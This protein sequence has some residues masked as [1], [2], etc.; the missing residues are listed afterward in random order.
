MKTAALL[1]HA[2]SFVLMGMIGCVAWAGQT[3]IET[4]RT[5]FWRRD[6][7][8]NAAE[9]ARLARSGFP[10]SI[11]RTVEIGCASRAHGAGE[12]LVIHCFAPSDAARMIS[13]LEQNSAWKSGLPA[14][15]WWRHHLEKEAPRDLL[16]SPTADPANFR[17]LPTDPSHEVTFVDVIRGISYQIVTRA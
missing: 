9:T 16:I 13:A 1:T 6:A 14:G 15:Q 11:H 3:F 2:S 7:T 10:R 5:D 8:L 12:N 17:Y 4:T